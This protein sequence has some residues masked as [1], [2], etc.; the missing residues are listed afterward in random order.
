MEPV[1]TED[2]LIVRCQKNMPV[3][4]IYAIQK[5]LCDMKKSGVVVVPKDF[6]ILAVPKNVQIIY[7]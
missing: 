3:A 7:D 2:M 1:G 5:A 6:S 4:E